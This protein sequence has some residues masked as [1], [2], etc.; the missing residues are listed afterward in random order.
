M[1]GHWRGPVCA[2]F[3]TLEKF[4]IFTT[5]N[6]RNQSSRSS[7]RWPW[8]F[9]TLK[10]TPAPTREVDM[11]WAWWDPSKSTRNLVHAKIW[12]QPAIPFYMT[13]PQFICRWKIDTVESFHK[14]DA[15]QTFLG[16]CL[17]ARLISKYKLASGLHWVP[18]HHI[19][20]VGFAVEDYCIA[21]LCCSSSG[22]PIGECTQDPHSIFP[23]PWPLL[24]YRLISWLSAAHFCVQAA[25]SGMW[26]YRG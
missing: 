17:L 21:H 2:D 20:N 6:L 8:K 9:Y 11:R 23:V 19:F 4:E 24:N 13:L 12:K 3:W 5:K 7:W 18:H 16:T 25:I 22:F 14:S 10:C 26:A 15:T 1:H